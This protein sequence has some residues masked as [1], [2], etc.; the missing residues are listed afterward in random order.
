MKKNN[1]LH[2]LALNFSV[3]FIAIFLTFSGCRT[4]REFGALSKCQFRNKD[5][6]KM[7]IG[8]LNLLRYNSVQDVDF[9]KAG[10][11]ALKLSQ[12]AEM[13]FVVTFNVEVKNDHEKLAALE[14]MDWILE[15]DNKD[16]IN[17]TST[18]RFEVQPLSTNVLPITTSF[19]IKKIL[20]KGSLDGIFALVQGR[21]EE[22]SR[23]RLKIKP[24]FRI[25]GIRIG[26]PGYIKIGKTSK[27]AE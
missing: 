19:D 18:E 20:G 16:V 14:R 15:V 2:F 7:E 4:F 24:R 26:Y 25:A 6:G 1:L 3:V 17:G 21:N 11:I 10:E 5:F 27:K 8:G 13:P 9:I 23:I 12:Q 22:D